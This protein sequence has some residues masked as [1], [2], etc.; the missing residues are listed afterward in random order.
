ML[1]DRS[2][3]IGIRLSLPRE[4]HGQHPRLHR[5][6]DNTGIYAILRRAK[7]PIRG[8]K[9]E[10]PPS[11]PKF[12]LIE[13]PYYFRVRQLKDLGDSKVELACS[14]SLLKAFAAILQIC[15]G[16]FE[17][18]TSRVKQFRKYGFAAYSLTV[19]PYILMS[20]V[21]LIASICRP[22]YPFVYQVL[23]KGPMEPT[24]TSP[25]K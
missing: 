2:R 16:S 5:A 10:E 1:L 18:Y 25:G 22:T 7:I 19:V 9:K 24:A 6:L 23:Y 15:Y 8:E 12:K 13:V 21:N 17:L 3:L 4:V 14:H 11:A 20:F